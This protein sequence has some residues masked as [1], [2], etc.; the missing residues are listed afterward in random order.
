VEGSTGLFFDRPE[1]PLIAEAVD[2]LAAAS[3]Q[4]DTLTAH[5]GQFSTARFVERINA[6]VDE[7]RRAH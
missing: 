5:A 2:R 7:E 4:A 6:A 1:P 3:W